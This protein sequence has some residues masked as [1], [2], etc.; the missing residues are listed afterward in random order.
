MSRAGGPDAALDPYAQQRE[1]AQQVEQLVARQLVVAAQFE[2]IEVARLDLDVGLVEDLL[3][4]VQLF[5]GHGVFHH[6]DGVVQ[7]AAFDKSGLQQRFYLAYKY[8]S[9][10]GGYFILELCHIFQ[11]GKLVG[12]DG[13]VVGYQYVQTE[14]F[15]GQYDD[16]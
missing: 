7:V 8:E 12:D 15:I 5:V 1:V 3:E 14:V 16:G 10:A 2:V 9:A 4:L 11:C 6:H 13:R